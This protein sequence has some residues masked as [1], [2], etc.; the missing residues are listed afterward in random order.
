MKFATLEE[1][2]KAFIDAMISVCCEDG[3]EYDSGE[4]HQKY[5]KGYKYLLSTKKI[6]IQ[7][8]KDFIKINLDEE[9]KEENITLMDKEFITVDFDKRGSD[10]IYEVKCKKDKV[11]FILLEIQSKSDKKMGYRLLNYILEIW[12]KYERSLK[13]GE[14]FILPKVIPCVLY[15]GKEKWTAPVEFKD[16]YENYNQEDYLINFKYILTDINRYKPKDLLK[17]SNIIGSAFYLDTANKENLQ[18][19]LEKLGKALAGMKKEEAEV[20][21]RWAINIL[22]PEGK[23]EILKINF[24]KEEYNMGNLAEIGREIYNDG[25]EFGRKEGIIKGRMDGIECGRKDGIEKT[26]KKILTKKFKSEPDKKIER[27]IENASCDRL[28]EVEDK[29]FELTSWEEVEEILS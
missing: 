11:Y 9:L 13:E 4:I 29:I 28:N 10:L 26:V 12:R 21:V 27:L 6:F 25:I 3:I 8:V 18:E 14:K 22:A 16:L 20:F 15:N 17:L 24:E 19:R 2:N 1:R 23:Q 5:D 7:F